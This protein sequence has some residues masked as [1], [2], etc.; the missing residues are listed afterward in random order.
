MKRSL[1]LLG[2]IFVY[3]IFGV[4]V[5]AFFTRRLGTLFFVW[6][7]FLAFLPY[8]FSQLL[9]RHLD[10]GRPKT[11][12]A[13]LLAFL[14]L[15]FFPN[16]P[17]MITD[18]KYVGVEADT[19]YSWVFLVYIASGAVFSMLM[20]LSSLQDIHQLLLKR[21]GRLGGNI[22]LAVAILAGG[23]AV[24]IGRFLRFNSWDVLQPFS[25]L[26]RVREDFSTFSV[27][28][29]LL[30]SAFIFGSYVVYYILTSR[31]DGGSSGL[32]Q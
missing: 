19:V 15:I 18:L 2:C 22:I 32:L 7:V 6:N 5:M 25:L 8:L 1:Y 29:S 20:G 16:A 31:R 27:L 17:Y 23:F 26:Q 3:L 4:C 10:G 13:V 12:V 21:I 28:F 30:F 24:Y 11:A 9:S 14:W